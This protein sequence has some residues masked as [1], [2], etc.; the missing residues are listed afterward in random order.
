MQ[1]TYED[2][3]KAQLREQLIPQ[4]TEQVMAQVTLGVKRRIL[5][6]QLE[7]KFG[8]V[9]EVVRLRVEATPAEAALDQW[10]K[11][12]V[13]AESLAELGLE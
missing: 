11:R 10:L 2:K 9:P 4:V 5:L 7:E 13:K 8:L 12:L 6:Q 3:L 1:M